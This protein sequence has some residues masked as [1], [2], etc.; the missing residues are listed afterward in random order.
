[1]KFCIMTVAIAWGT[2]IL[3]QSRPDILPAGAVL[4]PVVIT[5]MLWTRTAGGIF[6]GGVVLILDWIVHSQG[7]PLLP[8]VLTFG[9]TMMLV[10]HATYNGWNEKRTRTLKIPQWTQPIVLAAVGV[11]LLTGPTIVAQQTSLMEGLTVIR[12]YAVI[13][14]PVSLLLTGLMKLADEF[15]LRR[16]T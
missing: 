4:L 1:M 2:M 9:T 15:G 3:E 5:S 11:G 8:V 12:A 14:L 6:T 13:S 7:L 10:R 16:L